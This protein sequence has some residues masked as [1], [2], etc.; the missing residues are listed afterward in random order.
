MPYVE[1][2]GLSI[3][4]EVHGEGPPVVI[5][6]GAFAGASHGRRRGQSSRGLATGSTSRSAGDTPIPRTGPVR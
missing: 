1:V 6:H 4:H 5:L 3:W 2:E